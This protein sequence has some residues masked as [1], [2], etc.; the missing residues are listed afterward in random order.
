VVAMCDATAEMP[1]LQRHGWC[2]ISRMP[3]LR[4]ELPGIPDPPICLLGDHSGCC[5]S[6]RVPL[7]VEVVL[8]AA[9]E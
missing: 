8:A 1:S 4:R 2:R 3:S 9:F 6:G 7:G 5:R